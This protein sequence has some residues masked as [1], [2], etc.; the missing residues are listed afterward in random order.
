MR[1]KLEGGRIREKAIFGGYL[2]VFEEWDGWEHL[3]ER[4]SDCGLME[5]AYLTSAKMQAAKTM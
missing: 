5:A 3:D 1:Q 2:V 4:I